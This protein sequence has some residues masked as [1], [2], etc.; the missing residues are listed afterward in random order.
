MEN[1][2]RLEALSDLRMRTSLTRKN[3][4][5]LYLLSGALLTEIQA[6]LEKG[7]RARWILEEI[8]NLGSRART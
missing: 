7:D 3:D 6:E 2:I 1:L 5:R 8:V 4:E